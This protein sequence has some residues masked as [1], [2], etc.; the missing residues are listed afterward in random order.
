MWVREPS[1]HGGWLFMHTGTRQLL[2]FHVRV[3]KRPYV[4]YADI[5]S[6]NTKESVD[7]S[8]DGKI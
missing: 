6:K 8:G 3:E 7:V 4:W 1:V 5:E 2:S